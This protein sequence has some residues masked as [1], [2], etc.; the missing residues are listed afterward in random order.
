NIAYNVAANGD[1]VLIVSIESPAHK[2]LNR[3]LSSRIG[4]DNR[5]LQSLRLDNFEM[6][7]AIEMLR[8]ISDLPIY[9]LERERHWDTL[10]N[11]IRALKVKDPSLALVVLDYVGLVRTGLRIERYQELGVIS[12]D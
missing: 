12:A 11:S 7:R 1:P 3:L 5:K 2:I 9:F 6:S 4:V 10:Q 8:E